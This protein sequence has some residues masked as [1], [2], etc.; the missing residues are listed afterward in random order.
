[1]GVSGSLQDTCKCLEIAWVAALVAQYPILG[2]PEE[3]GIQ[4][5][6]P[7]NGPL[8]AV[9]VVLD[10]ML[11]QAAIHRGIARVGWRRNGL[12]GFRLSLGN[13]Y[14]AP[15]AGGPCEQ[16]LSP[17][18]VPLALAAIEIGGP[19]TDAQQG[20]AR[21]EVHADDVGQRLRRGQ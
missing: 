9:I 2:A 19:T 10:H 15:G 16:A 12:P 14:P 18:L 20:D 5:R 1:S 11:W 8:H 4:G 13:H 17:A 21:V 6:R 3:V 7:R